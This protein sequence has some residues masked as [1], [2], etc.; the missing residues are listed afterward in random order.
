MKKLQ[1]LKHSLL[2]LREYEEVSDQPPGRT[3]HFLG[4]PYP[5]KTPAT[6]PTYL[7]FFNQPIGE[8]SAGSLL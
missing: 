2:L 4:L 8:F 6:P 3:P 1:E 5:D 7:G